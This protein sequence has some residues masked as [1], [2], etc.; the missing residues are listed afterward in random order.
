M[1]LRRSILNRKRFRSPEAALLTALA[2]SVLLAV[3][4][5]RCTDPLRGAAAVVLR[6]GQRV[7]VT[8]RQYTGRA[9]TWT[10]CL[11]ENTDR[12][13]RAEGELERLRRENRRLAVELAAA[14]QQIPGASEDGGRL[15]LPGC[16]PALVLGSQARAFLGRRKLLDVGT[17]AGV[18]SDAFVI[19][20]GSGQRI[21]P[22]HVVLSGRHVWGKIVE[23][24][25]NTS[26]VCTITETGY[27]D[28]VRVG[29]ARGVLEGTG[30]S[31]ARVRLIDAT[32]PLSVG[33]P[34]TTTS[35]Q[36][37]L[38]EPL[39]YGRIVRLQRPHGAAHWEIWVQPAVVDQPSRVA[40]LR[41]ELNPLRVVER[42]SALK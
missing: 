15:I 19:D 9:T 1:N 42:K 29:S 17:D 23:T 26:T 16:V 31:L 37:E 8:A 13:S 20:R 28:L 11:F 21:A 10:K 33:D 32:E 25:R 14:R 34:V 27:R 35:G 7:A 12:L 24:G 41:M 4:P 30:Q 36:G 3:L 6:P 39:L 40:V 18:E 38:P 2:V 22:G 5:A